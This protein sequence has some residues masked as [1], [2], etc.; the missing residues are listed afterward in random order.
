MK[1]A[2]DIYLQLAESLFES[3]VSMNVACFLPR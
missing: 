3:Q 1:L 2:E